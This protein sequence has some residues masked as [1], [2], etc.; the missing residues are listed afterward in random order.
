M[1]GH[2]RAGEDGSSGAFDCLFDPC[3]ADGRY[4]FMISGVSSPSLSECRRGK[5]ADPAVIHE[6]SVRVLSDVSRC[7]DLGLLP[8]TKHI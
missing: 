6:E 7:L 5:Q 8:R 1:S 3:L 4:G 2:G